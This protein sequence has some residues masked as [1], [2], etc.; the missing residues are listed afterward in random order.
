MEDFI[1]QRRRRQRPKRK[2][3][4]AYHYYCMMHKDRI[5]AEAR[6]QLPK[7]AGK[8]RLYQRRQ[9]ISGAQFKAL[10]HEDRRA[11]YQIFEDFYQEWLDYVDELETA[12]QRAIAQ[13]FDPTNTVDDDP[14]TQLRQTP[15]TPTVQ[16]RPKR[17]TRPPPRLEPTFNVA[18]RRDKERRRQRK[19]R[20]RQKLFPP[21]DGEVLQDLF[22]SIF[23]T[24]PQHEDFFD[25]ALEAATSGICAP[26]P[27]EQL[28]CHETLDSLL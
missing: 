8:K 23:E 11:H 2:H 9:E 16:R 12:L 3:L 15:P 5:A 20:R 22:P 17:E 6:E 19:K 10:T 26:T 7:R 1:R 21:E 13:G 14:Y 25:G 18:Q 28:L 4:N 24:C 27:R